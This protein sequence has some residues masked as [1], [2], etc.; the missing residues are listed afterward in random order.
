[1]RRL[2]TLA[3][4]RRRRRFDDDLVEGSYPLNTTLD[5]YCIRTVPFTYGEQRMAKKVYVQTFSPD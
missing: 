2:G 4:L 5:R 1:M 3:K